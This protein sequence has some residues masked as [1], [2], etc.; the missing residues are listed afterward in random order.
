VK[1]R[2]GRAGIAAAV[3]LAWLAGL[4]LLVRRE[5]FRPSSARLLEAALRITPGAS[6][7]A[8]R[9]GT[10]QIGFAST[11]IDTTGTGITV[12]DYVV[13][14]LP[15]AGRLQRASAQTNVT[16]SRAFALRDFT[17]SVQ[18][19]TGPVR[20]AGR[21]L[22]D[23]LLVLAITAPGAPPDTQ[24]VRL[25]GPVLLPTL[26]PLQIA[27]ME[28]EVGKRYT[29]ATFDPTAMATREIGVTVAAE[30]LFVVADS[31]GYDRAA[32]RWTVAHEDTVRAW[33]LQPD[34]NGAGGASGIPGLGVVAGWVDE[35]G[36]LVRSAQP[37]GIVLERTAY[38][39]AFENWRA[40]MRRGPRTV[41]AD[42]DVLETTALAADALR[43]KRAIG[44][45]RVRLSNVDLAGFDL[46][47]GRQA[48]RG[49][50]L[51]I[52][53][54]DPA[55]LRASYVPASREIRQRFRAE[56][57]PEPLIQS[58][59]WPIVSLA[60]RIADR[61]QDAVAIT[62]KI[63]R[64][65]HDSLAKE[66]SVGVPS[67]LQV[68]EARRGDC[69]EHAVLAVAMLR[70][71]GIPARVAAGLAYIDGKFYYHAWPEVWL[72]RWV[73]ADPT[74]GEFPADAAHLR[75]V[76]GGLSRQAELLRLI[77]VLQV[78]VLDAR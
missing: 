55:T 75:F 73:A 11:T 4:G 74:F 77:D 32:Q 27:L 22:G 5:Y 46:D 66:I 65:V 12:A 33:R 38:E 48:L 51:E 69:N 50:T 72:D 1:R 21:A 3:L 62:R 24:R 57:S 8:V 26:V 17:A 52:T 41:T 9:Q 63:T 10:D 6:F 39:V 37:G 44:R 19:E 40:E 56:T 59:A 35:Q 2:R 13:A 18:S 78:D 29:F 68:L 53:R 42:R 54:E 25:T 49:D 14:D 58:G 15:L 28:P 16:L 23:T 47:G 7:Y 70:A 30:S 71:M 45:L 36:R 64:W 61:D 31:A 67:A 43:G 34:G 20:V 76:S 60:V